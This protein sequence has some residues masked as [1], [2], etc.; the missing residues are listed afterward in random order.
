MQKFDG[1]N[2]VPFIDIMLVLL[3]IVLATASFITQGKIQVN[4]PK[5]EQTTPVTSQDL[6]TVIVID[7][8]GSY[9]LNDGLLSLSELDDSISKLDQQAQITVKVDASTP[10]QSFLSVTDILN[11]YALNKISV[12]T[13]RTDRES[14]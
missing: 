7:Q 5:A 3:A 2:V 14:P 6:T 11:K 4:L 9:F 8:H 1:I 13:E 12:I 10:F